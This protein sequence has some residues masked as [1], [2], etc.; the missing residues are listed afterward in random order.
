[1][2]GGTRS[3]FRTGGPYQLHSLPANLGL[4]QTH[5]HPEGQL[6]GWNVG[7]VVKLGPN[8]VI[9]QKRRQAKT[10]RVD[11]DFGPNSMM[12][13][14]LGDHLTQHDFW[15][16]KRKEGSWCSELLLLETPS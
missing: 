13:Q 10:A 15:E 4:L 7:C 5:P 9:L 14:V 2:G 12:R 1:M 11:L 8:T 6:P 3:H 16:L